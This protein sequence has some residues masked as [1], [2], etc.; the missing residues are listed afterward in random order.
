MDTKTKNKGF[1]IIELMITIALVA[2]I[3]ALGVPFFR[4]T[5]IENRLATETNNFIASINHARSLAAKRNQ[6]VTMCISSGVD[7]SGGGSCMDSA[8]GWEQG[9]IVFND[10]DRDGALDS[11]GDETVLLVNESLPSG[12]TLHGTSAFADTLTF[13]PF[14]EV[15]G[16]SLGSFR[17][18]SPDAGADNEDEDDIARKISINLTGRARVQKGLDDD[19]DCP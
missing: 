12:Y 17:L 16:N 2:I 15:G 8:I 18:C 10:I 11:G 7:S 1:T 4:A 3:L 5:I 13:H 14:G 19:E 6:S 9:W